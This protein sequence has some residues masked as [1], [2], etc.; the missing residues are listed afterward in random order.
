[1]EY[2]QI[3]VSAMCARGT[4]QHIANFS[5]LLAIRIMQSILAASDHTH[6]LVLSQW[7]IKTFTDLHNGNSR[8]SKSY[9]KE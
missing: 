7:E 6:T 2:G 9:S 1:M 4:V 3:D 8:K 5:T